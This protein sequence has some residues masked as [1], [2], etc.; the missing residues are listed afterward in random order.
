MGNLLANPIID[1]C[2]M[3]SRLF[4]LKQNFLIFK[5]LDKLGR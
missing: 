4:L 2:G 1:A 5:Q 3:T